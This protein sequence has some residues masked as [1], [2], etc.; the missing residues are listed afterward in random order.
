[1]KVKTII[2]DNKEYIVLEKINLRYNEYYILANEFDNK[3]L[4]IRKKTIE[5]NEEYLVGLD[6]DEEFNLVMTSYLE[7]KKSKVTKK[8]YPIGTIVNLKDYESD[9]MIIGYSMINSKG[10]KYDYCG[11][12]YPV[13]ILSKDDYLFFD[14]RN[15]TKM[16]KIG[17]MDKE[18]KEV[19]T[20]VELAQYLN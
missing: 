5:N 4:C 10:V 11:C 17:C 16:V 3:D 18:T 12:V 1:M 20:K 8:F 2:L 15:I 9:V 6:N 19:L 13:G 14:S 7:N